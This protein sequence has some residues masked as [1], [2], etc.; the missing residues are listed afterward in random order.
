MLGA[1]LARGGLERIAEITAALAGAPVAIVVPRLGNRVR[2]WAPYARYVTARLAGAGCQR[3]PEVGAEVPI[4]SGGGEL[5]AVLLLGPGRPEA[6]QYLHAA[7][8]TALTEIAVA[9]A[10]A[11]TEDD[12]RGSLIEEL[13]ARDD[14][15]AQEVSRRAERL[16]VDLA[17]GVFALCADP[18]ERLAARIMAL[19]A[20]EAPGAPTCARDGRVY[21]L[22]PVEV[23]AQTLANRIARQAQVGI[24]GSCAEPGDLRGALLEAELALGVMAAGGPSTAEARGGTYRLLLRALS[25]HPSEVRSFYED[26]V[27]PLVRY[28]EEYSTDLMGT[29]A[30]YFRHDCNANA[31]AQAIYTHRHTVRYRLERIRELTGLDPFSS[32]GRELLGL[33]LK[34][35]GL[36]GRAPHR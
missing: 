29:L 26:T 27:A 10:R 16:G 13:L 7:A 14:L 36:I 24:S 19:V 30:A 8:L 34:A 11:E 6:G 18:G 12:L 4:V 20:A 33:G 1:V 17:G 22:V 28:D 35:H 15:D 21:A 3:P 32:Q 31:T 9:E 23:G 25:T 2:E 5:G